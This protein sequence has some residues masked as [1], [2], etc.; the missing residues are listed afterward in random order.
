MKMKKFFKLFV[1]LMLF[2]SLTACAKNVEVQDTSEVE[3]ETI[4]ETVS[5][6]SIVVS[7]IEG[8]ATIKHSD[9]KEL[10]A[11]EGMLLYNGDD[12]VVD[13]ESSLVLDVDSDKHLFAEEN[14][15]FQISAQGN[16]DNNQTKIILLNGAVLCQLQEKLKD[17][18]SF[19]VQ[20]ATSTMCVRGT[21]FRVSMMSD[22]KKSNN[23]EM[24]EVYDGKVWSSIDNTE[25]EVTLEPGQC[26]LIQE[27]TE[28][29]E[30]AYVTADQI[31]ESFWNSSDT[32]I[33]IKQQEAT[34][35]AVLSIAYNKLPNKVVENLVV[36]SESGQE[37][38]LTT[39][40]LTELSETAT[41]NE[42][43]PT[44][45]KTTE[46]KEEVNKEV[47]VGVINENEFRAGALNDDICAEYGH[48]IITVNG[49]RQ[50]T[51]CG[52]QFN[53]EYVDTE[54]DKASTQSFAESGGPTEITFN[55][56][57]ISSSSTFGVTVGGEMVE[58]TPPEEKQEGEGETQQEEVPVQQGV[59]PAAT[60]E[61][62]FTIPVVNVNESSDKEGD[63]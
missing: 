27:G 10:H 24:V 32:N 12:V 51:I 58:E 40:E 9:G 63:Q 45:T 47:P 3:A 6:R 61:G 16:E 34:G 13:E 5:Y 8:T 49:V 31:D 33:Q 35:S 43:K 60:S 44:V 39:E 20:T 46:T 18:E 38:S 42:T 17:G 56:P 54:K 2:V 57:S 1:V 4:T 30:S 14:A 28:E 36:I 55:F 48:T 53:E 29:K 11:Y 23:F 15:H 7:S 41:K 50:C 62:S 19:D 21:V 59:I 22:E 25:N 26:A 37:L 52:R